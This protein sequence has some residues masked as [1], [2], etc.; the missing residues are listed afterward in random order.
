MRENE[1]SLR[2][3]SGGTAQLRTSG[4]ALDCDRD[5]FAEVSMDRIR[6]GYPAWYLRFFPIG[7]G[8]GY[9]FVK[10]IGSG[11]DQDIGLISIT[12]LS[13]EW[14]KMSQMAVAVFPLLCFLYCQYVLHSSQSMAIL[15][16]SSLIF[17]GQVEVV[18]CF[19]I[20]G[21]GAIFCKM[22]GGTLVWNQYSHRVDAEVT[23][24]IYRFPILFLEVFWEQH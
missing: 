22:W 23:F 9:S 20:A 3:W 21:M 5:Y 19:Y 7:I 14:F 8:F 11:Q 13:W 24:H 16:T 4:E 2:K 18:S 12:N 15:V 17:S 10:Q 6:I 1:T